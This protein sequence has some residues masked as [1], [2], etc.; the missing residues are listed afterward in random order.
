MITFDKMVG[1][2]QWLWQRSY[3]GSRIWII[4]KLTRVWFNSLNQST[5]VFLKSHL[6]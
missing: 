1:L 3:P 6:S 4:I 5:T 2:C